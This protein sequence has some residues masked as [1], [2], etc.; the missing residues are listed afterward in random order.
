MTAVAILQPSDLGHDKPQADRLFYHQRPVPPEWQR[1]LMAVCP[2]YDGC[3]WFLI[4][5][6]PGEP[7]DPALWVQR[8]VIWQMQS[9]A[10]TKRLILR[11]H[12]G[13]VG[14]HDEHP[15]K[16]AVWSEKLRCYV[17]PDG[18]LAKTDAM[19]Y[20]L[21]HA[22]GCYGSRFWVIQG[23]TGGHRYN[24]SHVEKQVLTLGSRGQIRDVPLMG[25]LPY[26]PFDD[27]VL[28]HFER[29]EQA[30]LARKVYK[31]ASA[32][33]D[34]LDRT[35]RDEME[36]ARCLLFDYLGEQFGALYDE[37]RPFYK[38]QLRKIPHAVGAKPEFTDGDELKDR[39]VRDV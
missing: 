5:W 34:Q 4:A 7:H 11:D 35:D 37:F 19:T 21:Y 33:L 13:T 31:Y 30:A 27:R 22:T 29:I 6:E 36:Y 20:E 25:D 24:L 23:E 8:Y 28:P 38:E 9:A 16:D 1:A 2:K 3:S 32:R 26:A 14:F 18:R 39:F 10:M 17:K 12:P 15:R